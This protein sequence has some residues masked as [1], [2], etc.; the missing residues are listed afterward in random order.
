VVTAEVRKQ[1]SHIMLCEADV[2]QDDRTLAHAV[3]TFA[4]VRR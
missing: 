1:G 2:E 3:A 4:V